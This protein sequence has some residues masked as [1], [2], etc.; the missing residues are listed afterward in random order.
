KATACLRC[1]HNDPFGFPRRRFHIAGTKGG[2]AIQQLE[3]G[4]FTLNLDQA[5]GKFK[6]GIQA[7]Q[8]KAG[9]SY[10][11]EFADLAK[12]IRGEKQLAWSYEHDLAVHQTLLKICGMD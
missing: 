3:S 12:V 10:T 7:V 6:K 1:N 8:L 9:R 2:M 4:R 5:R 11:S